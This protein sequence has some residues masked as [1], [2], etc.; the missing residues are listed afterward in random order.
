[1]TRKRSKNIDKHQNQNFLANWHIR[2]MYG[3]NCLK[4]YFILKSASS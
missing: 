1:M 3:S 2:S 4:I